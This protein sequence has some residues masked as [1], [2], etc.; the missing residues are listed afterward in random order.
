MPQTA[1]RVVLPPGLF[2]SIN[3]AALAECLD[4]LFSIR[5]L[6]SNSLVWRFKGAMVPGCRLG[7]RAR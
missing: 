7:A 2:G 6:I 3:F 5:C 1:S 4:R